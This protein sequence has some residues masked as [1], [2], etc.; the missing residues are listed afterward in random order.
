MHQPAGVRVGDEPVA[1]LEHRRDGFDPR[2]VIERIAADFELK[3]AIPFGP[4]LGN[5]LSH[6][7]RRFL[8]NRPIERK[9]VPYRPPNN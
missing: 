2:D 5:P 6:G 7:L 9:I 8:R 3:V 1:G 4:I